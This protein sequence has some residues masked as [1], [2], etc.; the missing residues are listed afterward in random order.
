MN[1]S[2][3]VLACLLAAQPGKAVDAEP[4]P[5]F[6]VARELD[7]EL[8][9][10]IS[11]TWRGVGLRRVLRQIGRDRNIAILLDRRIDPMQELLLNIED[12][13]LRE[14][15]ARLAEHVDAVLA[16]AGNTVCI[17]P[18]ESA[19]KLR[20]L[21]RL[22]AGELLDDAAGI[23]E[24]RQFDLLREHTLRW[25]DFTRPGDLLQQVAAHYDLAVEGLELV[26]H[27]LWAAGTLPRDDASTLLS[28]VLFQFDLTFEW[29]DGGAGIRLVPIPDV[30]SLEGRYRPRAMTVADAVA[31]L[32]REMPG[33]FVEVDGQ[34][35]RIRGTLERLEAAEAIIRPAPV[36]R[37]RV[38]RSTSLPLRF[39]QFTI[40]RQRVRF[41]TLLKSL[42][43]KGVV[44]EY[45]AAKLAAAGVDLN[46]LIE[47]EANR[48]SADELMRMVCEPVGLNFTIDGLKVTLTPK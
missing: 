12:Q 45:D 28:L 3:A 11:A 32:N 8:D 26:P 34:H 43:Q 19:G 46:Q 42:E 36:R 1:L 39:R 30:V 18:A 17:G 4:A 22:R 21:I 6:R 9:G 2:A 5:E 14:C 33:L 29:T 41:S 35:V 25:D 37:R 38:P 10:R 23:P 7:A 40:R 16:V 20:T 44:F 13:T 27:D 31:L 15:L 24:R 47:I 48:S